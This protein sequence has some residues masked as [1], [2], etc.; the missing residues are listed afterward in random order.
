M[1][2]TTTMVSDKV[3]QKKKKKKNKCW[4]RFR[5]VGL[6][7]LTVF[8]LVMARWLDQQT[9]EAEEHAGDN[10]GTETA[11]AATLIH[12]HW[13]PSTRTHTHTHTFNWDRQSDH[14]RP[15]V[16]SERWIQMQG[17]SCK[18]GEDKE[19]NVSKRKRVRHWQ[20]LFNQRVRVLS[21]QLWRCK[22]KGGKWEGSLINSHNRRQALKTTRDSPH[23]R[24][25]A[26]LGDSNLQSK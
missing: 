8:H 4:W 13:D 2:M 22:C 15:G 21:L 19:A 24:Q 6:T 7:K 12:H 23:S 1:T 20:K 25:Q 18:E 11:A 10:Q 5:G 3:K 9:E 26:T 14:K 16:E 17:C